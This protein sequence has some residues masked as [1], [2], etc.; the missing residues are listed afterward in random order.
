MLIVQTDE[1]LVD[2]NSYVSVLDAATYI[3]AFLPDKLTAWSAL[4]ETQQE[5]ALIGSTSYLDSLLRW[6]STLLNIDQLLEWPRV[7]FTDA[8]GRLVS[9][10]PALLK[11]S[12][13]RLTVESL[14]APLY[15]PEVVLQTDAY[16]DSSQTFMKGKVEGTG[17]I[18][19][20][21][22][23]LVVRGYGRSGTSI[24]TFERA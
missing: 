9:G 3:A 7:S 14:D 11:D 5:N 15:T 22:R 4:S 6:Q 13:V 18:S 1:S 20:I 12:Q 16:G 19:D 2:A 24:V 10:V 21:R 17:V 8:T 23:L